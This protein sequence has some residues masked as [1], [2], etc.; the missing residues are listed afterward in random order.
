MPLLIILFRSEKNR[1]GI[2]AAE[3]ELFGNGKALFGDECT[4]EVNGQ[5]VFT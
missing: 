2:A 3:K 4:A 1:R 5:Y